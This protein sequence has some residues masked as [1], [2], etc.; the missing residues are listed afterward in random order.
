MKSMEHVKIDGKKI[1]EEVLKTIKKEVLTLSRKPKL[2]IVQVG[3][4]K[5]SQ[6][7]IKM[8]NR[9][10]KRVGIESK[11]VH[12]EDDINTTNYQEI[13]Q[14]IIDSI[15]ELNNDLT[16]DGIIVQLPLPD[17]LDE[18]KILK[19][20]NLNKDV[21]SLHPL[22]LANLALSFNS[23]CKPTFLPCTP[24]GCMHL[25]DSLDVDLVGKSAVVI[26]RST[27]VGMPMLFLLM[28]KRMNVVSCDKFTVGTKELCKKA[29]LIVSAAGKA[30][31]V[32]EDW[33]KP[34]AIVIDVG[35]NFIP[36]ATRKSGRRLV[37]DVDY[38]AVLSKVSH[39]TPVPGGVGPMTVAM[40]LRNTLDACKGRL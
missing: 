39:I 32:T 30:H 5:D 18:M 22:N 8:K 34:G 2:A 4:R 21:D 25:L 10:A 35:I 6:T 36:D 16:V 29:D 27:M 31:L 17:L 1:S 19:H 14:K 24:R 13:E 28:K 15:I 20:I 3:S 37:G 7:Y 23:D 33:V 12:F 38:N 40:L 11:L 26:G 9:A